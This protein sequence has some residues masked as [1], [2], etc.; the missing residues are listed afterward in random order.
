MIVDKN[1]LQ[2]DKERLN[3]HMIII[4]I[5]KRSPKRSSFY[6]F[7][8]HIDTYTINGKEMHAMK[9]INIMYGRILI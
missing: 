1:I 3:V 4:P 2:S 7:M 6:S 9:Y 8:I 5:C